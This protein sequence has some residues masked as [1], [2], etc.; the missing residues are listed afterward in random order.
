MKNLMFSL[1]FM[2]I[3]SFVFANT[4]VVEKHNLNETKAPISKE[5]K[6]S[7]PCTAC[8]TVS[9]GGFSIQVCKTEATCKEAIKA[10]LAEL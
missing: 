3:G 10:L 4:Q 9:V 5:I 7:S 2:L 1:M 8:A 6:T